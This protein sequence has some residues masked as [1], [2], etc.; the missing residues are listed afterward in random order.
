MTA[1]S[2]CNKSIT[3]HASKKSKTGKFIP[4]DESTMKPH[5]CMER[6]V[7]ECNRCGKG[8]TFEQSFRNEKTGK[9]IP[10]NAF[11]GEPHNC[12]KLRTGLDEFFRN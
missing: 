7:V 1:C 12:N 6:Y 11:D 10:L 3:F 5:E 9:C 2:K 4:L 8:I